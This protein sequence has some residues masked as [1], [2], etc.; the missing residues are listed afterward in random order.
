MTR[1]SRI[2]PEALCVSRETRPAVAEFETNIQNNKEFIPNFG[3]RRQ[4]ERNR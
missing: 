2:D 3:E 4:G 1:L